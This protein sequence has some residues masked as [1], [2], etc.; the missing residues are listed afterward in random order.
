MLGRVIRWPSLKTHTQIKNNSETSV[1][2]GAFGLCT[3]SKVSFQ[4]WSVGFH[5]VSSVCVALLSCDFASE[6]RC[7]CV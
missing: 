3:A 6:I 7:V 5:D 1:Q 4:P 2:A